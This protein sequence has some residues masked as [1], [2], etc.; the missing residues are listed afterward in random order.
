MSALPAARR[1]Y[2]DCLDIP[3]WL[4]EYRSNRSSWDFIQKYPDPAERAK[5]RTLLSKDPPQEFRPAPQIDEFLESYQT[6]SGRVARLTALLGDIKLARRLAKWYH[7]RGLAMIL[8]GRDF[9]DEDKHHES[10]MNFFRHLC[11][12]VVEPAILNRDHEFIG[13]LAKWLESGFDLALPESASIAA[14]SERSSELKTAI[15]KSFLEFGCSHGRNPTHQEL[16]CQ[17]IQAR[18]GVAKVDDSN[19]GKGLISLGLSLAKQH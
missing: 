8:E 17:T 3:S 14:F 12:T 6:E 15:L 13:D 4:E 10:Y 7:F 19:F 9:L 18:G 1:L 11:R 16:Q 2:W 5:R